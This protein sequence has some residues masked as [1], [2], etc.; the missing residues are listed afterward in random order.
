M[1]RPA[2]PDQDEVVATLLPSILGLAD[3]GR[4]AVALGGS[5]AKA[6]S[7]QH[8]DYDFRVYA[9]AFRGPEL[10]QTPQWAAFQDAVRAVE[11]SGARIDGTWPRKIA[12]I[13][14][15]LTRWQAGELATLDYEWTVWGYHLPTDIAHQLPIAD[16][17]GVLAGWRAALTI[18]P[19]ALRQAVFRHFGGQLRY[20]HDDYHYASK[21]ERA[22]LVFL[23]G[24]TS[25]LVHAALQVIFA[26]NRTYYVGDGWNL[27]AAERLAVRP[28]DFAAR[29]TAILAPT[30][31]QDRL[32]R[33]YQDLRALVA[34]TLDLIAAEPRI[35]PSAQ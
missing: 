16:P 9:D 2:L 5:R 22:D 18:Y 11:R 10:R 4:V 27:R 17:D 32:A 24:L 19:D 30:D 13:D 34:D 3:R 8:S 25:K 14:A 20:W 7:D 28:S 21:V 31:G 29:V 35:A 26:L 12:E 23:A 6:L 33:Q 1:I 15:L